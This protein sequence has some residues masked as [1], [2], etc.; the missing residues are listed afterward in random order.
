MEQ[1]A[2]WG[3]FGMQCWKFKASVIKFFTNVKYYYSFSL[4]YC[5]FL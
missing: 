2:S 5:D 1:F 3:P 4:V